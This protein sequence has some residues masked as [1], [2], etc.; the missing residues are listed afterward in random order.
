MET[1]EATEVPL[2]KYAEMSLNEL[3]VIDK[4]TQA[5]LS[6]KLLARILKNILFFFWIS[7]I[8]LVAAIIY[9]LDLAGLI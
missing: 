4:D 9:A 8:S 3:K 2:T 1:N 5:A 6:I 7:A